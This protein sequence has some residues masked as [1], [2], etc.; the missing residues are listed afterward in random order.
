MKY[1]NEIERHL[2]IRAK[3]NFMKIQSD[4]R[5]THQFNKNQKEIRYKSK[6]L[7]KRCKIVFRLV[8]KLL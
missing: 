8:F 4:I 5:D 3:K 1:I 2:N 6:P 7:L